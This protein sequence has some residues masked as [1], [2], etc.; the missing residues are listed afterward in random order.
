MQG[1]VE[2]S[3]SPSTASAVSTGFSIAEDGA[4]SVA[5]ERWGGWLG[6]LLDSFL[7]LVYSLILE[8]MKANLVLLFV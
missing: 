3:V 8:G 4:L 5:S 7:D 6:K 2:V 1:N